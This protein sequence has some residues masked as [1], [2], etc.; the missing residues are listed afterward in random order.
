MN[1]KCSCVDARTR[2][3]GLCKHGAALALV[4]LENGHELPEMLLISKQA[5]R[6]RPPATP[7][8]REESPEVE[9][10]GE[11]W[12]VWLVDGELIATLN[13]LLTDVASIFRG[14]KLFQR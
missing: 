12:Y 5:P 1:A 11:L 2:G 6:A 13:M 3:S 14:R 9:D 7:R 8:K 10:M 4:F